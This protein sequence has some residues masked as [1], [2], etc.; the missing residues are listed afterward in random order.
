MIEVPGRYNLTSE[1]Y[2]A[3][4]CIN[5]SLSRSVIK[6]LIYRSPAHAWFNHSRLNPN[7]KL[8][9]GEKKFDIGNACHSLLLEGI[10]R[11]AV[12]EADD[13]RSKDAK[14][15]R[16][17]ARK[18]GL[19]PL[20][21]HQ[22][23]STL[24]IVRAAE[25]QIKECKELG[26]TNLREEGDSELSYFWQEEGVWLKVRPDWM[27]R[28]KKIIIDYKTTSMSAN[29]EDLVRIIVSNGYDIQASL[30]TRG[31]KA[32]DGIDPKFIFMFQEIEEPYLC[33]FVGLPPDF[34]ELGKSKC[35]YGIFLW[36]ECISSK[37]W[38]GYPQK[39]CWLDRPE[40][41][42]IAWDK[43]AQGLTGIEEGT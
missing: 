28:D 3:D 33:S 22:Y 17:D 31:V 42:F 30:Y 37:Q 16:E 40:W 1:E 4:P 15:Q 7:F 36:Q 6:D 41:A 13:W 26:I 8:E 24:E 9:E 32:I 19:T 25:R 23:D 39:V 5:P 18:S 34:M 20:L 21:R 29:P 10:D 12:I 2:H 11:V 27:P 43:R 14:I 38:P 35:D